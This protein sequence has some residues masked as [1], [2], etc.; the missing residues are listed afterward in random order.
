MEIMHQLHQLNIDILALQET[1]ANLCTEESK[2]I[3]GTDKVYKFFFSSDKNNPS[4]SAE[5]EEQAQAKAIPGNFTEHHGVGF[6]KG[7]FS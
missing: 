6:V 4:A 3:E 1:K 7:P 2:T 5:V